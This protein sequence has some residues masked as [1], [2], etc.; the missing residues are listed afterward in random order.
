MSEVREMQKSEMT[1]DYTGRKKEEKG[2]KRTLRGTAS[3]Q[4]TDYEEKMRKGGESEG[5]EVI[6]FTRS[7]REQNQKSKGEREREVEGVG[8]CE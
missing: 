5:N 2:K 4:K 7:Q 6:I 3:L 1:G 8:E